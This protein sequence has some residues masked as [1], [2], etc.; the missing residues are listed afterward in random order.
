MAQA[1][2]GIEYGS[3][4]LGLAMRLPPVLLLALMML[5]TAS[6]CGRAAGEI[7]TVS[8]TAREFN[9]SGPDTVPAG[10]ARFELTNAG[11]R[12]HLLGIVSLSNGKTAEDV[13]ND[14]RSSPSGALPSYAIPM[15]G[16][17]AVDPG[18][19]SAGYAQ[20]DPGDYAFVCIMPDD[21]TGK[22]HL[23]RG[24]IKAFR[25]TGKADQSTKPPPASSNVEAFDFGYR[26][27]S[28]IAAGDQTI[29][30]HNTGRQPHEAQLARLPDGVTVNQYLALNDATSLTKGSSYGGI[31]NLQPGAQGLLNVYFTPGN[32][33]F[34]CFV[35]DP[36]TGKPHFELGQIEQF[37]VP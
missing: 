15:G 29:R 2:P 23:Y 35:V 25:V 33:A 3:I 5:A 10:L 34:I 4:G 6:G 28:P 13:L 12:A 16:P 19:R 36:G 37:T 9:F 14:V 22:D 24:M 8:L 7:P 18:I 27:D 21:D 26:I 32:Y 30:V 17:D 11:T 20:L 1:R 31:F